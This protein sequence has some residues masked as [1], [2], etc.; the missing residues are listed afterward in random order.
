[1]HSYITDHELEGTHKDHQI[2]FLSEWPI[3]KIMFW[4]SVSCNTKYL[5]E[6]NIHVMKRKNWKTGEAFFFFPSSMKADL[7][8]GR[9]WPFSNCQFQCHCPSKGKAGAGF[10]GTALC[11]SPGRAGAGTGVPRTLAPRSGTAPLPAA[12]S[13]PSISK[14]AEQALNIPGTSLFPAWQGSAAAAR[15]RAGSCLP[16][17]G[18]DPAQALSLRRDTPERQRLTAA[19]RL[20]RAPVG[21]QSC[22]TQC[23]TIQNRRAGTPCTEKGNKEVLWQT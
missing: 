15:G 3:Y 16:C 2:Q 4:Q 7:T 9:W 10:W 19:L 17:T 8:E 13:S 6:E 1:M 5:K 14:A 12:S 20:Q 23:D 22:I 18:R 21:L 11:W